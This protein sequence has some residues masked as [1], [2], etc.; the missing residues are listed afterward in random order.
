[1][2]TCMNGSREIE[3]QAKQYNK[4][5]KELEQLRSGDT[6]RLIPPWSSEKQG[7]IA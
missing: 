6:V 1:M 3:R 7:S 2:R 5:A 4:G